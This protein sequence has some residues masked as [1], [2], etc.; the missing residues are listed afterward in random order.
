MAYD[1]AKRKKRRKRTTKKEVS[2][3]PVW[4]FTGVVVG[5]FIAFL[6]QLY[7]IG[8]DKREVTKT[9]EESTSTS[10]QTNEKPRSKSNKPRF[11]F[12]D[13]LPESELRVPDAKP[14][15]QTKSST[16]SRTTSPKRYQYLLQAG[17]FA[18]MEDADRRKAQVLLLGTTASISKIVNDAGEP[19]YRVIVGPYNERPKMSQ[20]R[21]QLH[22][23]NIETLLMQ[24]EIR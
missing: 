16:D 19:R 17:S 24:K 1:F 14:I 2:N 12:Y 5:L 3:R 22:G 15:A 20:A 6:L 13:V 4:F 9:K 11:E 18:K 10:R 7:G 21:N 23:A 8:F